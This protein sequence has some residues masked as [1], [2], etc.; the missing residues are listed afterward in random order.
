MLKIIFNFISLLQGSNGLSSSSENVI[1][2]GEAISFFWLNAQCHHN[3]VLAQGARNSDL[4]L[5]NQTTFS[6]PII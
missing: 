2:C 3:A 1:R 4:L 6:Y 5:R